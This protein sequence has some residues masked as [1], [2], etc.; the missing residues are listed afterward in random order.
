MCL[1]R[2]AT[3][4][5]L[6]SRL[7]S[8]GGVATWAPVRNLLNKPNASCSAKSRDLSIK[9]VHNIA[10]MPGNKLNPRESGAHIVKHAQHIRVLPAGIEKLTQEIV[11]GLKEKRIAVENFS[12]HE[13]HPN[14]NTNKADDYSKAADWVF[15]LDTLNFCFWTPSE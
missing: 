11:K 13:L 2:A 6:F 3:Q 1:F 14:P 10:K 15:V 12:Q 8:P 4:A 9:K 5:K 7:C